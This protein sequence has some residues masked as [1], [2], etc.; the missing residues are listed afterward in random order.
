MAGV[1][2]SRIQPVRPLKPLWPGCLSQVSNQSGPLSLCGW[3]VCLCVVILIAAVVVVVITIILVIPVYYQIINGAA[4]HRPSPAGAL[5]FV[6]LYCFH[7]FHCFLGLMW[8]YDISL[9]LLVGVGL[10]QGLKHILVCV[11]AK[12]YCFCCLRL[13]L[14]IAFAIHCFLLSFIVSFIVF[15]CFYCFHCFLYYFLLFSHCFSLKLIPI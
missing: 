5:S 11:A 1:L 2:V 14:F 3:G 12:V 4:K 15:H 13:P 6:L 7:C 8:C 9:F 10:F